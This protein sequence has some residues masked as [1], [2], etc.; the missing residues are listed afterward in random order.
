M[1][2]L[3]KLQARHVRLSLDAWAVTAASLL[4]IAIVAGALPRI[5]W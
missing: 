4:V 5:P 1:S 3:P 2:Q